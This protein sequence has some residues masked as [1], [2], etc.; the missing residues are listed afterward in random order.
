MFTSKE[1]NAFTSSFALAIHFSSSARPDFTYSPL[2]NVQ[3]SRRSRRL[4]KYFSS[5]H[6]PLTYQT[7]LSAQRHPKIGE[8]LPVEKLYIDERENLCSQ[9]TDEK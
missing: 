3:H 4:R 6:K 2:E 8:Y 7:N 1:K 5:I 9:L